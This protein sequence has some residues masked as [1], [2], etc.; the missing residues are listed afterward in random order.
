MVHKRVKN[1]PGTCYRHLPLCDSYSCC[2]ETR[3]TITCWPGY[4]TCVFVHQRFVSIPQKPG[5]GVCAAVVS[6]ETLILTQPQF[7]ILV[8][9]NQQCLPFFTDKIGANS[10]TLFELASIL[11]SCRNKFRATGGLQR[12]TCVRAWVVDVTCCQNTHLHVFT[13][14]T[15][16][17][18]GVLS[19][20]NQES[21]GE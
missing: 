20:I 4:E 14:K 13:V 17:M 8:C 7:I 3:G 10:F 9:P 1:I 12:S 2:G 5:Y 18:A 6:K 16:I 15:V 19:N 21:G 11:C